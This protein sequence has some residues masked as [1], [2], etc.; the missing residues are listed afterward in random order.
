MQFIFVKLKCNH[1]KKNILKSLFCLFVIATVS[2]DYTAL[3]QSKGESRS[4]I[5]NDGDTTVNGK[6]FSE[7][8]RSERE[9]LRK[10]FK[11]MEKRFRSGGA[12]RPGNNDVVIQRDEK[13]IIISRNGK[14][15]KVLVW[16][17][18]FNEDLGF[19]TPG[20]LKVF[21]FNGD[22]LKRF[23]FNA[24]SLMKR[25][26]FKMDGLD[27]NLRKRIIT[28]HRD[29]IP[30]FPGS[31]ERVEL[32]GMRFEGRAFPGFAE[33]NNSSSFNYN[34]TDKDGISSHMSIRIS[35]ASKDHLKKITGNEVVTKA[36]EVNDLTLFPNFSSGKMTLSFNMSGKGPA[37]VNILDSEMKAVFTDEATNSNGHY[38][39]QF[40]LPKNGV[41]HITISQNGNW[42]VKRI[43]K[44]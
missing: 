11:E 3:A 40:M 30:G 27:S 6:K 33:R 17:D 7:L 5:I 2:P 21:K 43:I 41:Y 8:D 37:K 34:Y 14:E 39:K 12:L 1:M 26:D 20:D 19:N 25:F 13:D 32:P 28:M 18:H 42:F 9:R 35:D 23:S 44:E 24:D 10:E 4:V 38:V 22:S 36:L 31:F 15:P 29:E 16:R